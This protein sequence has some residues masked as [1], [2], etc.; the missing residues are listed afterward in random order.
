M[1]SYQKSHDGRVSVV[2][3][4]SQHLKEDYA[5]AREHLLSKV[6]P[7]EV[8]EN[9]SKDIFRICSLHVAV[10]LLLLLSVLLPPLLLLL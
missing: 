3:S 5:A 7:D 2:R 9:P 6:V 1:K 8:S 10:L 4:A